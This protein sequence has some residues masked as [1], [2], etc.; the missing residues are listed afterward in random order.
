METTLL[1]SCLALPK[2]AYVLRTCL[3]AQ[4]P[5]A[6]GSFDG[7]ICNA[8]SDLAGGPLPDWSWLKA[9]LPSYLGGVEYPTSLLT[10]SCCLHQFLSTMRTLNGGNSGGMPLSNR[11]IFPT[12]SDP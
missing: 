11:F 5:K 6:L 3:P 9:S 12:P 2:V 8:L 4:I 7:L 10:G 1:W